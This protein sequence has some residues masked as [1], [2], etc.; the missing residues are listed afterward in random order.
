MPSW[1][2]L[3]GFKPDA[4]PPL[5]KKSATSPALPNLV[6]PA[7]H[8]FML[9]GNVHTHCYVSRC[10]APPPRFAC[11][12]ALPRCPALSRPDTKQTLQ[13]VTQ[14]AAVEVPQEHDDSG[15]PGQPAFT[16]RTIDMPERVQCVGGPSAFP[17]RHSPECLCWSDWTKPI[18]CKVAAG[19]ALRW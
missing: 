1:A 2:K 18:G 12:E 16:W 10:S 11:T 3:Y 19:P 8:H 14:G 17:W 13:P 5:T 7:W 6:C 15:A 4:A 9:L